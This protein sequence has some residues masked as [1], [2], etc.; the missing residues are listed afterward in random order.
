MYRLSVMGVVVVAVLIVAETYLPVL[1]VASLAR[2]GAVAVSMLDILVGS[3]TS[4]AVEVAGGLAFW[5]AVAERDAVA[6]AAAASLVFSWKLRWVG[7]GKRVGIHAVL[8][9]LD[10]ITRQHCSSSIKQHG[11]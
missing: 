2:F 11:Q 3:S 7:R 10:A 8:V 1:V 9:L 4:A 6:A 5:T